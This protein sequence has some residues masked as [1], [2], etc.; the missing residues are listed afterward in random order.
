LDPTFDQEG[1]FGCVA[2]A[3]VK[4]T[5]WCG[6]FPRAVTGFGVVPELKPVIG[7]L[8]GRG[9]GRVRQ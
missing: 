2:V 1:S 8:T 7:S 9:M 6:S 5:M 3:T 4:D